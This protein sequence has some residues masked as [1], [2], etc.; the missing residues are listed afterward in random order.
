[1][2][3]KLAAKE[4]ECLAKEKERADLK[5]MVEVYSMRAD[6]SAE[7]VAMYKKAY[8][9]SRTNARLLKKRAKEAEDRERQIKEEK[10]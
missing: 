3:E 6:K 1:M 8:E 5:R 10:G 7:L 4:E 2:K 9:Q